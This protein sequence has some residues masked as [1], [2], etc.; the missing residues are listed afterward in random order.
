MTTIIGRNGGAMDVRSDG[1]ATTHQVEEDEVFSWTSVT[2]NI[3]AN[4]TV[5][6]V[7]NDSTTKHLHITSMYVYSDVPSAIDFFTP[8]FAAF[9]GTAITGIALNRTDV[10]IAPA[11]ALGDSSGD[12]L[13]NIFAK[14]FTNETATDQF[15]VQLDLDGL[16]ILGYHDSAAIAIVEASAVANSVIMGYYHD[17]HARS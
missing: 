6:L 1:A 17:N 7:T 8:A 12:T 2:A 13:A 5:I 10:N 15:A 9:T 14:L 11:T 16:L 3:D 4:D